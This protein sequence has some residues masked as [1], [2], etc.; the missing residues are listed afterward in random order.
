M[1]DIV[2]K[3]VN[4]CTNKNFLLEK[5]VQYNPL[6]EYIELVEKN[7]KEYDKIELAKILI[8]IIVEYL[9]YEE[10]LQTIEKT[11][12]AQNNSLIEEIYSKLMC[13]LELNNYTTAIE[14]VHPNDV[15]HYNNVQLL[16]RKPIETPIDTFPILLN[17]WN[18][19]RILYNFITIND[20]N[21][22]DGITYSGNIDNHYL[23]PMGIVV[24]NRGNHSQLSG[25]YRNRGI[26]VIK[27]I[28]DFSS[29][30][31]KVKFNGYDYIKV[32]D[33]TTIEIDCNHNILFYSGVIFELGRYLKNY[34]A[35]KEI[36]D[37]LK[38]N[39]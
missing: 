29:L 9:N 25:R 30:Y 15:K 16:N 14:E 38:K 2:K 20:K 4:D 31:G 34:C 33:N 5:N 26:T 22:F 19:Y 21:E 11:H 24:C 7:S 17:P 23:H 27:E 13:N 37:I 36:Q 12:E 1:L 8:A 10:S 18:E 35:I 39:K 6:Q 32:D 3:L 28:K